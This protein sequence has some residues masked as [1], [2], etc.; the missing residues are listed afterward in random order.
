MSHSGLLETGQQRPS[1]PPQHLYAML[2][3]PRICEVVLLWRLLSVSRETSSHGEMKKSV[4]KLTYDVV[5]EVTWIRTLRLDLDLKVD[6]KKT[7]R[8][9][10]QCCGHLGCRP[11]GQVLS[12]CAKAAERRALC[13]LGM[14]TSEVA[15]SPGSAGQGASPL[16]RKQPARWPSF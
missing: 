11:P 14:K 13:F 3:L 5:R 16:S 8:W 4:N 2:F 6:F 10:I 15:P 9:V 7:I 1:L 12:W